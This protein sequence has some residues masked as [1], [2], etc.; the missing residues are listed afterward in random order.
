MSR[1]KPTPNP[2]NTVRAMM[3]A[4]YVRIPLLV[5]PLPGRHGL[6]ESDSIEWRGGPELLCIAD[7]KI[8]VLSHVTKTDKSGH[9]CAI[10]L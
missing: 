7:S 1:Q 2:A 3:K 10:H 9:S 5:L 6:S 8:V 4:R